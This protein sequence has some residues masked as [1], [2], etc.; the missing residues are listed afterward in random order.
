MLLNTI[1]DISSC[2]GSASKTLHASSADR[3][4]R[5]DY[6]RTAMIALQDTLAMQLQGCGA[7]SSAEG[8]WL[9]F[10]FGHLLMVHAPQHELT[11]LCAG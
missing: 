5:M 2:E 7:S 9:G 8:S 3:T 10:I 4:P 6:G 11:D 1:E